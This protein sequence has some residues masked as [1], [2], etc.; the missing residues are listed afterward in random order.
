MASVPKPRRM[1][2]G[3]I[4]WRLQ[5]RLVPGG[6]PTSETFDDFDSAV[7]F[8]K[9][10]DAVGGAAARRTRDMSGAV[11]N[12]VPTV[13]AAL[14]DHFERLAA[15]VTPGTIRG[16]RTIARKR[17]LPHLGSVPVTLVTRPMVE[18]WVA[19]IRADPGPTGAG[20]SS[21]TIRET[22][23]LLSAVLERQVRDG[24]IPM[25]PAKGVRLPSDRASQEMRF[26]T[27]SEV[28]RI[29]DAAPDHYRVFIMTMFATGLR[30]GEVTA[31][32]GS[33]LAMDGAVPSVVVSKAWKRGEQGYYLGSPKSS[34]GRRRVPI[35]ASL[36]EPLRDLAKAA[37]PDGLL[38]TSARGLRITQGNFWHAVW[39]PAVTA[40]GIGGQRPR[41]HD[42]RHSFA[43]EQIRSGTP[44]PVL[45]RLMGHESV[46]TTVD[47]YGHIMPDSLA[48][49]ADV[50]DSAL[51][52]ALPAVEDVPEIEA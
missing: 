6:P 12:E 3:D 43:S 19:T 2:N 15:S 34:R 23:H 50:M 14:A 17:I 47:T 16:Y 40:A 24:V 10:V 29:V 11:A 18:R 1:R 9:L 5:F 32:T 35:P 31:L 30:F 22:H 52:L 7:A 38:F 8:G 37:G 13:A 25:N 49:A 4:V 51:S 28:A 36:R 44:L 46:K 41:V 20:I 26:L 42:L 39:M 21:K 27:P 33:S 45:Q 48:A